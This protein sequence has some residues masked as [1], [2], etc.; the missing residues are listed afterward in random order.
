MNKIITFLRQSNRYKHLLGGFL[1]GLL[2][3]S[4]WAAMYA[5]MVAAS[6]LELKD[7]LRGSYWDWLDWGLTVIGGATAAFIHLIF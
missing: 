3:F 7:K 4:P 2:A 6:C 1:V 5:A